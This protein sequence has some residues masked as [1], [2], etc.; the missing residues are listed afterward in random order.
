MNPLLAMYEILRI[1]TLEAD[2]RAGQNPASQM[3]VNLSVN[4]N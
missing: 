1:L 2:W 4:N 3:V